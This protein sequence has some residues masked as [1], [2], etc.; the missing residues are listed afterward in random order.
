MEQPDIIADLAR[1]IA[2]AGV[3]LVY[4]DDEPEETSK[5]AGFFVCNHDRRKSEIE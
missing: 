3:A 2:L 1:L 4:H 5:P